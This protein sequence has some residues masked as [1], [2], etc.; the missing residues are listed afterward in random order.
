MQNEKLTRKEIID[1]RLKQAGWEVND[2]TQ[3]IEEFFI[4]VDESIV[5]EHA[6]KYRSEFSDHVLLGKDGKIIAVIEAKRTSIVSGCGRS[7]RTGD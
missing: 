7:F 6:S 2:R 5:N 1:L 4:S 3:V